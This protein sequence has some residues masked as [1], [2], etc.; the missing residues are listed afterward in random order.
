MKICRIADLDP[1]TCSEQQQIAFRTVMTL[2]AALIEPLAE[3]RGEIEQWTGEEG[4]SNV[5]AVVGNFLKIFYVI[6]KV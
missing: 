4:D 6:E 3:R 2:F 1:D 5:P